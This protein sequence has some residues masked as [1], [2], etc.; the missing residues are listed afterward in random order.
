MKLRRYGFF[1]EL[2][3][4]DSDGESLSELSGTAHYDEAT[5]K[6]VVE[7]LASGHLVV[8]CPGTVVDVLAE[9]DP[10]PIGS[11]DILTDGEWAW[12]GDLPYYVLHYR[13]PVPQ[14]MLDTMKKHSWHVPQQ[15]EVTELEL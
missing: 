12:P 9:G 1:R 2:D 5:K 10:T 3:H 15:I 14:E 7:Y 11:P 8:G 6:R 13:V 4:G